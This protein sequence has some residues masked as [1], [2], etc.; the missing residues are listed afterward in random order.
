MFIADIM[1]AVC[2]AVT[3]ACSFFYLRFILNLP[4]LITDSTIPAS[5]R[6]IKLL[7]L[8]TAIMLILIAF[9][10]FISSVGKILYRLKA[11]KSEEGANSFFGKLYANSAGVRFRKFSMLLNGGIAFYALAMYLLAFPNRMYVIGSGRTALVRHE[12]THRIWEISWFLPMLQIF[13]IL[14]LAGLLISI[15]RYKISSVNK[16]YHELYELTHAKDM[17]FTRC[18]SC[19]FENHVSSVGCAKCEGVLRGRATTL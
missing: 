18:R 7:I 15:L 8:I 10:K 12:E 2:S 5:E 1:A 14:F 4:S 13:L 19:G 6:N 9:L 17:F 11:G 16:E 3:F